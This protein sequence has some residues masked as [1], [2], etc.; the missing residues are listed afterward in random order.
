MSQKSTDT[1]RGIVDA[2]AR[3]ALTGVVLSAV[4]LAGFIIRGK[5][6]ATAEENRRDDFS[7]LVEVKQLL[8]NNYLREI[9]AETEMEY[10]AIRGYLGNLNDPYTFFIDPPVAQSESDVLAGQYG[11]IGVQIQRNEKGFLVLYPFPDSPALKAGVRDGDILVAVDE[12]EIPSS[13]RLDVVDR[14]LR[15]EVG[16]GRGVTIAVHQSD[17]EEIREYFIEFAVVTVPSVIWRVLPEESTF[18]YI[19]I[20]RFTSRTPEELRSAISDLRSQDVVALILDLRKNS[21]G[22]LQE[23]VEVASEFLDGGVVF[24]E[25]TRTGETATNALEGGTALDLPLV[26]LVD[27]GTASAAELVAGAIRDRGRGI[28]IGQ[29]TYGKG[30]VQLIFPL[31]DDSSIHITSAEW[32]TP[33]H[34]VLDGTGLT[35]DI[36]MIPA[37]DGRDVELGEAVRHL[38]QTLAGATS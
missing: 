30:S 17:S 21:G 38:Q 11:G 25:R 2:L 28:L 3:G 13:E 23:S 22:L 26:V 19:Q 12:T 10:A 1:K 37:E 33:A 14:L 29:Q 15:G 9:P 35:P 31:S 16:D 18:G 27:A 5:G 8:D 34:T 32:F 36:S 7:L 4:F 6:P 20:I 24:Y